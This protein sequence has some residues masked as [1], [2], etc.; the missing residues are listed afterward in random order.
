MDFKI[1]TEQVQRA[2]AE[3]QRAL[4]EE[5]QRFARRQRHTRLVRWSSRLALAALLVALIRA[6][7]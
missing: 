5:L 4:D 7:L 1:D 6:L 3:S 2:V